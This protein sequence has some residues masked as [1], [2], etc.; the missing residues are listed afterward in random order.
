MKTSYQ[1]LVVE[2][3]AMTVEAIKYMLKLA[4]FVSEVSAV[5]DGKTALE[6]VRRNKPD[7]MIL[8][9]MLPGMR[10]Q[11]VLKELDA[12]PTFKGFP[13]LI[14]S[15]S[16]DLAW[17]KKEIQECKNLNVDIAS[18]PCSH[19]ELISKLRKLINA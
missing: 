16:A 5:A 3:D 12:D 17:T 10:G 18:R 13:V 2:D 8:D 9:L 6:M 1:L 11:D 4:P 7:A 15:T 14:N 19:E